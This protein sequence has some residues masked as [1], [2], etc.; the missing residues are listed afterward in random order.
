[1]EAKDVLSRQKELEQI[2]VYYEPLMQLIADYVCPRRYNIKGTQQQGQQI[3]ELVFDGTAMSAHD[4]LVNGFCGNMVSSSFTWFR[5]K[6]VPSMNFSRQS[7]MRQYNG[8][9]E[10]IP[11]VKQYLEDK[12]WALYSAFQRSNFYD[13]IPE[14]V[15]DASSIGTAS[16]YTEED[17]INDRIVCTTCHPG[18]IFISSNMYGQVDTIHR[19]FKMTARQMKQRFKD[20]PDNIQRELETSPEEEHIIIHAVFPRDEIEMYQEG[21]YFHQNMNSKNMP[22]ASMYIMQDGA[23]TL[24]EKGY[25]INPFATWRWRVNTD[26]V[27]GR[28]PAADA[29]TTILG[30]NIMSKS[31]L[32][33]AQLLAEPPWNIPEEMRGKERI[34]PRGK[35]YFEDAQRVPTPISVGANYPIGKDREDEIREII[36]EFFHVP[37]FLMLSRAAME[38]RQLSV[39]QVM[40]MQGE[41]ASVL[42]TTVG[43][44]ATDGLDAI[45][46]RVDDIEIA[47]GRMPPVPDV[48]K[49]YCG[50]SR[51]R[52][53]YVGP[54]SQA[55]KRLFRTSGITQGL[56]Q[57]GE[58]AALKPDVL[59]IPNWDFIAREL[60]D[61]GGMPVEGMKKEDQVLADRD[62]RNKAIQQEAQM[63]QAMMMSQALP[64]IQKATD[65]T[66]PLGALGGMVQEGGVIPTQGANG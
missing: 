16:L 17:L 19:K 37:F 7:A 59:D 66:S 40:E 57:I 4:L 52:V 61:A 46:D 41:K 55:Q 34:T 63:K 35:N 36:K 2:R 44:F 26:E 58:L 10:K 27:Y 25:R 49:E 54:L 38:G 20:L 42:G 51:I 33:V 9:F 28:S 30:S 21:G 6:I 56:Q 15:A 47:A 18:E 8:K 50:G 14:Y 23:K 24:Q 43:R 48:V 39:P 45:I 5:L 3:G 29:I 12:E 64:N 1:M 22:F 53:D 11:E 62:A 13:V 31:M 65:P 60:L 32:K